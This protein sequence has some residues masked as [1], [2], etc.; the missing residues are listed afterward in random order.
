VAETLKRGNRYRITIRADRDEQWRDETIATGVGGFDEEKM[1]WAHPLF[2]FFRRSFS[3]PWFTPIARIG[4]YGNDEYPLHPVNG[5]VPDEN[6]TTLVAEIT[7]RRDGPLFIFVNDAVL[8]LPNSWQ[9]FYKN[10]EGRGH[11]T[12]EELHVE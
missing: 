8:P 3:E 6:T 9:H 1:G 11:V 12:V 5:S 2:V 7:A 4:E 10:N